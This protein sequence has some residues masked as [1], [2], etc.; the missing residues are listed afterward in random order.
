MLDNSN[1]NSSNKDNN[2]GHN[3]RALDSISVVMIGMNTG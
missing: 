3:R 2:H 1:D